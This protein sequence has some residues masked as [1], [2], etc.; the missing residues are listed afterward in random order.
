MTRDTIESRCNERQAG[1]A[2][3]RKRDYNNTVQIRIFVMHGTA[4][5][6]KRI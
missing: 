4:K 6:R 3:N 2:T 1:S 5:Q